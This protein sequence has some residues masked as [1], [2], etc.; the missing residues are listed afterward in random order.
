MTEINEIP[1]ENTEKRFGKSE[2]MSSLYCIVSL[3][4]MCMRVQYKR[5]NKP[6]SRGSKNHWFTE[7]VH[8]SCL[9]WPTRGLLASFIL[10]P[11]PPPPPASFHSR[12][13]S[14]VPT[15][16]PLPLPLNL[17]PAPYPR[18]LLLHLCSECMKNRTTRKKDH[19]YW[20]KRYDVS[21]TLWTSSGM[22]VF[23]PLLAF[24]NINNLTPPT[25]ETCVYYWAS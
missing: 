13:P 9:I 14:H 15:H 10:R 1:S 12:S 5:W 25:S 18:P 19:H 8:C 24:F 4:Q 11:P 7:I 2:R 17:P 21:L 20:N 6:C 23:G 16:F 3:A 22:N